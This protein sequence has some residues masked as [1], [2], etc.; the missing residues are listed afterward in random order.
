MAAPLLTIWLVALAA[1]LTAVS[2]RAYLYIPFF[3]VH[4][5]IAEVFRVERTHDWLGYLWTPHT[6]ERIP[7]IRLI[8]WIDVDVGRAQ[9][10]SFLIAG[11]AAWLVGCLPFAVFILRSALPRGR[12]IV[13]LLLGAVLLTQ[14]SLAEDFAFPVFCVYLLAAGP[15]L[16]AAVLLQMA[17]ASGLRAWTFW[18]AMVLAAA[19]SGGNA[20]G[21]AIWPALLITAAL[22]R[23]GREQFFALLICSALVIATIESGLGAPSDSL[24]RDGRPLGAHLAKM[25]VYALHFVGLPWTQQTHSGLAL[26]IGAAILAVAIKVLAK[27]ARWTPDR[28]AA[29]LAGVALALILF[30]L[31]TAAM[32]TIGRVDEQTIA[33]V[34]TRY[35]PF[36]TLLQLGVLMGLAADIET[37]RRPAWASPAIAGLLTLAIFA[38]DLHVARSLPGASRRVVAAS[39][40]FDQDGVAI[41]DH[42]LMHPRPAFA[43]AIR[44]ELAARGLPH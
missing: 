16:G 44:R 40:A 43:A 25:A 5:W 9:A 33:S 10:P 35:T 39:R 21:L 23:R 30:G 34:P 14:V 1:L 27:A 41:H 36:A 38:S 13:V 19:A 4:D 12:R 26:A 28:P 24:G 29:Q 42:I 31:V 32:A 17:P 22:Q 8:E 2:L 11:M 20:A 15:A 37:F 6:A 7:W 3:D 18:A